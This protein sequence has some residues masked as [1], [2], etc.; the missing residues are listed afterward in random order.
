MQTEGYQSWMLKL[1]KFLL[2]HNI[3][4]HHLFFQLP[5]FTNLM[6]VNFPLQAGGSDEASVFN[7]FTYGMGDNQASGYGINGV[8]WF[9]QS[10]TP[11]KQ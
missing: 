4:G 2:S 9:S 11:T 1:C 6:L 8:A 10:C 3:A 5:R 7:H